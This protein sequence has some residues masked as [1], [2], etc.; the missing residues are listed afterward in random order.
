M[1]VPASGNLQGARIPNQTIL[2]VQRVLP[3][4]SYRRITII[5]LESRR[6]ENSFY[7]F[8]RHPL[9]NAVQVL[10]RDCRP[11]AHAEQNGRDQRYD[12]G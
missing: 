11:G 2:A 3:F 7:F 1:T 5:T 9:L 10:A 6:A 4:R 8:Q 12:R